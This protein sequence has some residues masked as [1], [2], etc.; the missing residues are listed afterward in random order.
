MREKI[1]GSISIQQMVILMSEGNPGG[2]SVL[3]K[4]LDKSPEVNFTYLLD[5]DDMNIRGSQIWIGYKDYCK[6]DLEEF[7]KAVRGRDSK[8]V[9]MINY[10][11]SGFGTVPLKEKAVTGGASFERR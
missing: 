8:M 5:L 10:E 3:C 9:E 11:M 1:T 7:K 4:L 2:L 6:E